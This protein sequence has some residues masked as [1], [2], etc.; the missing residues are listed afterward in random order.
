MLQG[1][2]DRFNVDMDIAGPYSVAYERTLALA[3]QSVGWPVNPP[4]DFSGD[5][6]E[7]G[8]PARL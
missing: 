6:I 5:S 3:A 7:W 4:H 2:E 1:E 8:G